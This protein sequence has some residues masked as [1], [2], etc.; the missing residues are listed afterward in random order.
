MSIIDS[1]PA[2]TRKARDHRRFKK[3]MYPYYGDLYR[4]AF[5]R[6]GNQLDAEDA[7][8][9]TYLK[10]YRAFD[11]FHDETGPKAWLSC[12]L[13][14]TIRDH[15]R[16][17]SRQPHIVPLDE[18]RQEKNSDPHE[19]RHLADPADI[20]AED[21]IDQALVDALRALPDAFLAPLLLREI[22]SASY[23]AIASI[24]GIPIGTV[25][26]RLSRARNLLRAKLTGSGPT[27]NLIESN[28]EYTRPG[29]SQ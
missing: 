27:E 15:V 26:S 23:Q 4:F 13:I 29:E 11:R 8:Q 7:V 5:A 22:N 14:N 25:M 6:L 1:L 19:S 16:K 20:V 12:I 28:N 21:E 17:S 24:L 2:L 10:A 3:V 9:E 18:M